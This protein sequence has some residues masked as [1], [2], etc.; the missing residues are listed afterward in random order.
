[1]KVK[2]TI[3]KTSK[4]ASKAKRAESINKREHPSGVDRW[5]SDGTINI[6]KLPNGKKPQK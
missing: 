3:P 4:G 5:T 1:M 2:K 6:I